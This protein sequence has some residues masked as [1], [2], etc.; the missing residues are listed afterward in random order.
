[1]SQR[2]HIGK[3]EEKYYDCVIE[4]EVGAKEKLLSDWVCLDETGMCIGPWKIRIAEVALFSKLQDVFQDVFNKIGRIYPDDV[5]TFYA[6][7]FDIEH[8]TKKQLSEFLNMS[9]NWGK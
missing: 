3:T 2:L 6:G 7:L 4:K 5:Y 9:V 8:P 1:M